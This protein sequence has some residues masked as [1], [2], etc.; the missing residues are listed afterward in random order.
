FIHKVEHFQD[1]EFIQFFSFSKTSP[2]LF[3]KNRQRILQHFFLVCGRA[4]VD[5][6]RFL[7]FLLVCKICCLVMFSLVLLKSTT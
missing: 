7:Y 4:F 3:P 5:R 6:W 2:K 1:F